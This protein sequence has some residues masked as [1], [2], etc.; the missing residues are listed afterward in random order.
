MKKTVDQ[1]APS[2][3]IDPSIYTRESIYIRRIFPKFARPM[4]CKRE[5][6]SQKI[7]NA[8]DALFYSDSLRSVSVDDICATAG[9]SKKAF[10]Y[11]FRS[12]D[13]LI[14]ASV[15]AN[16]QRTLEQFRNWAGTTGSL[17][18][19]LTRL[20]SQLKLATQSKDWIGCKFIRLTAELASTPGHPAFISAKAHKA[21]VKSWL[22][23]YLTADGYDNAEVM[24]QGLLVL[25]DGAMAQMLI[26]RDSMYVVA[27]AKI[28]TQMLSMSPASTDCPAL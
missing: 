28:A 8:A 4:R 11:H 17:I 25:L 15:E 23:D 7:V 24:A 21:A 6:S 13:E 22:H 10:Y 9:V 26:H 20:F 3:K 14:A 18:E 2:N 12:K 27:A 16:N 19:K 5:T 1:H